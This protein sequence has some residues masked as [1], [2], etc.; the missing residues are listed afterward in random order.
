MSK[1]AQQNQ[2]GELYIL[3]D[4]LEAEREDQKAE[5][6]WDGR[7]SSVNLAL[8]QLPLGNSSK[9]QSS[10]GQKRHAHR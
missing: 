6:F 8:P 10:D 2:V 7:K 1:E 4:Q 3:S 9:S 5:Y